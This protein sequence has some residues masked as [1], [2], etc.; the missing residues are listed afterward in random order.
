VYEKLKLIR[1]HGRLENSKDDFFY[2]INEFDYIDIGFN[3]RMPSMNASLGISQIRHSFI[4]NI[5]RRQ[6]IALKISEILL[7][8]KYIILPKKLKNA[9]HL[10]LQ[11]TIRL[12]D[13]VIEER[14]N[15]KNYLLEN[16]IISRVYYEPIHLKTFYKKTCKT[17][18]LVNTEYI[19]KSILTLPIFPTMKNN[20]IVYMANKILSFFEN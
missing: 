1:S 16:G 9:D 17:K 8:C 6:E 4:K 12:K 3:F 14:D 11:Y 18:K 15:L 19:S 20:E 7:R 2:S 10:Y 13:S 5:K